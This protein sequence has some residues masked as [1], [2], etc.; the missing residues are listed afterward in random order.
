M[1]I[2]F[3]LD[4]TL[5]D[6]APEFL[7]AINIV[8]QEQRLSPLPKTNKL[9]EAVTFGIKTITQTG[10]YDQDDNSDIATYQQR[11]DRVLTVYHENLG[12]HTLPFPGILELLTELEKRNIPWGVV[13]N[14]KY[15]LA[16]IL[17]NKLHLKERAACIIGGDS[18]TKAKPYPDPLL[19]AANIIK[20][21]P[22]QCIYVGDAKTDIE[23]GIAAGMKTIVA[24]FGYV[25]NIDLAK[26]WNANHY[27]QH[28]NEILPWSLQWL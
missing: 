8:R 15:H 23:A 19:L 20:R 5:L 21:D 28:A 2:L 27:V 12:N 11:C 6:T 13:T 22:K 17:L 7:T 9:R 3:D 26:Q 10:F 18:A 14:K 24:L 25:G 16:D 1:A 4:G